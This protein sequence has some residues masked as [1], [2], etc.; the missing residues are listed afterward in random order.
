VGALTITSAH[1]PHDVSQAALRIDDGDSA[2]GVATDVGRVTADLTA[3]LSECDAALVEANYCAH[4]LAFSE[5][6]E[7]VRRRIGSGLG[8]LSNDQTAELA[9][10]LVG[11]RLT[12]LWLGHLSQ[13]NNTPERALEV[14]ASRAKRIAVEVISATASAVMDVRATQPRQLGLPFDSNPR[15]QPWQDG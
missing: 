1:V 15:R 8:H 5:Y 14:V 3:L 2:F 10:R 9:V 7:S 6:P 12:R 4:M 13:S 11:S